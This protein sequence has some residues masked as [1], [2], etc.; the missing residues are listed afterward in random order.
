MKHTNARLALAL[1]ALLS[2]SVAACGG[3][4]N[5]DA[6]GGGAQKT[7]KVGVVL[8]TFNEHPKLLD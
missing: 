7:V 4:D 6:S 5:N 3:A 8:K 2:L 1:A